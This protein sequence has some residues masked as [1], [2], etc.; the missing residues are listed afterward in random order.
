MKS[1]R[2]E[3]I[4]VTGLAGVGLASA[5]I[6]PEYTALY[7][8]KPDQEVKLD[9][10]PEWVQNADMFTSARWYVSSDKPDTQNSVWK[11]YDIELKD[12]SVERIVRLASANGYKKK[13]EQV[14]SVKD[15][16]FDGSE[17][18]GVSLISHIPVSK[19]AFQ[20]AHDQ[21]FRVVPYV[22]FTDIHSFYADQD[23][24]LF[25]HPEVLLKDSDG[26][27]VHIPM[28]GTDRVFRFL[29][30]ANNPSYVE[31]S[32][33]YVKKIMDM[34]AD[35]IFIDNTNKR[36]ECYAHKSK[37]TINPEFGTYVHEHIYPDETH[38][39][40]FGRFLESV[41][42]LVKSYG[43]SKIVILNSGIGED[44]QKHG[45]VCM[46]ESFIFARGERRLQHSWNFIKER[47]RENEWYIKAGR[48]I[49]ALS[50]PDNSVP[51]IKEDVFWAFCAARL[52]DFIWWSS[53]KG[54][55]AE[56]LYKVHLGKDLQLLQENNQ[57]AYRT[58]ENGVLVLNDSDQDI[59]KEINLPSGF[60]HK[61]LMDVFDSNRQ[62]KV[63]KG[64]IQIS[65]PKKAARVYIS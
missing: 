8:S 63:F 44:F 57:V 36:R 38:N 59:K 27:W 46:W 50:T 51:G 14:L 15:G 65:V 37:K 20:Q 18:Q 3:F 48:R 26:K 5:G 23:V 53:L 32:L 19:T 21:G 33:A 4:K 2:R 9:T 40:A 62:L 64:Q 6:L 11:G 28:D 35:G 7:L 1:K 52:V 29:T 42:S 31:L 45:D 47:A 61:Q 30:C 55:G 54:T 34:G 16:I 43:N 10:A 17:I 60:K 56:Q 13:T 49:T 39:Y 41:R 25:Q 22:H 24:F 12:V 58:F